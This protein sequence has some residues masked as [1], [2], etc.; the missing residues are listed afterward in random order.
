M[1]GVC[2]SI[3]GHLEVGTR[4][5]RLISLKHLL[6]FGL[7]IA[8]IG[9]SYTPFN[10]HKTWGQR[11]QDEFFEQGREELRRGFEPGMLKHPEKPGVMDAANQIGFFKII[12]L[13]LCERLVRSLQDRRRFSGE[14]SPVQHAEMESFEDG[15]SFCDGKQETEHKTG[16]NFPIDRGS[17]QFITL[18]YHTTIDE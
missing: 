7:Q 6:Y 11:L 16:H 10:V 1:C 14:A 2:D 5:L 13:P 12:A 9:H 17:C 8:D 15:R 4:P 3:L 18:P